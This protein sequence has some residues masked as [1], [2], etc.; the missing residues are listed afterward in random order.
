M[1][2]LMEA[3]VCEYNP[4]TKEFHRCTYREAVVKVMQKVRDRKKSLRAR[5]TAAAPAGTGTAVA[6]TAALLP[7]AT[8]AASRPDGGFARS[9]P[10]EN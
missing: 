9:E 3:G 4:K 2:A 8:T 6:P 7:L 5:A 1:P 10:A